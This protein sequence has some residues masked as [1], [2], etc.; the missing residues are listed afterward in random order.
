[1]NPKWMK[2]WKSP[3]LRV[4]PRDGRWDA[5]NRRRARAKLR[6]EDDDRAQSRTG[7]S[8]VKKRQTRPSTLRRG[9]GP[10]TDET[11]V[12]LSI[13]LRGFLD[14]VWRKFGCRGGFIPIE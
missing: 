12:Y 13:F 6:R 4:I 2:R 7:V 14:D 5:M 1:M 11:S 3:F 8:P 10:L 9:R